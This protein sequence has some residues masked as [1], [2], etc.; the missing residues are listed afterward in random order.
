MSCES[1][2]MAHHRSGVSVPRASC[3]EL[4][5]PHAPPGLG[6]AVPASSRQAGLRL[7]LLRARRRRLRRRHP[8]RADGREEANQD[9][10]GGDRRPGVGTGLRIA[11]AS[12]L[13][14]GKTVEIQP[15][16]TDRYGRTVAEVILPDGR[17]LNREMVAQGMA[18]R[19]VKYAPNDGTLASLAAGYSRAR[20]CR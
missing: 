14:F 7:E 16:T 15:R 9:P 17:S 18:W 8:D 12:D 20:G 10:P 5:F 3:A 2:G 4:E 11:L 6:P 19:H 13:A 1:K